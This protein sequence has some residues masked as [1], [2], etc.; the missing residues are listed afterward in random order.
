MQQFTSFKIA[1]SMMNPVRT[2]NYVTNGK[3]H[4]V[5]NGMCHYVT[6]NG[7]LVHDSPTIVSNKETL[8]QDFLEIVMLLLWFLK[9]MNN[10]FICITSILMF[11]TGLSCPLHYN[12]LL[13]AKLNYVY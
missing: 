1:D 10:C 9:N 13:F 8:V 5:K 4:Y 7:S 3:C 2:C 6:T 12:L 11:V